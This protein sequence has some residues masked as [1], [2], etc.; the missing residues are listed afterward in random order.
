MKNKLLM[1]ALGVII[2]FSCKK[3]DEGQSCSTCPVGGSNH[4]SNGF[5]YVIN[6]G[7]TVYADSAFYNSAFK[8]ITSYHSGIATRVNIKTSS[9]AAGTYS[10]S[11]SANTLSY[12][13]VTFTYIASGGSINITSNANNKLSG[14]FVS[15]GTGGGVTSLTGQFQDI[16]LK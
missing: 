3:E 2:L 6:N 12:T 11:S 8:T 13:E 15:N 7:A 9:Q 16:P 14:N 4:P 5:S 10:F 1:A